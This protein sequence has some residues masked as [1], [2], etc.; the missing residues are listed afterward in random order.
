MAPPPASPTPTTE[1][2]DPCRVEVTDVALDCVTLLI[3]LGGL[4]GNGAVLWLLGW[5]PRRD[6]TTF[7]AVTSLCLW[8]EHGH[9]QMALIAMYVLNFLVF[10]PPMVISSTILFIKVQCGSQQCPPKRL[11]TVI[12]LTVLFFLLFALPL[13]I[14]NFLQQFAYT[15]VPSQLVFLL[16][17][18][19]SSINPI[20]YVLVG[21]CRR[22]CSLV[23]PRVAFQRVFEEPEDSAC[24]N[25]TT[26]GTLAPAC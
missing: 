23:P 13:S 17:C 5:R 12:F 3:C 25:T 15:H 1:G 26:M 10:A 8:H 7:A 21:T 6:P 4:L 9:C 19:N 11:H 2:G 20:T 14:S 22:R 16:A 18:I 24:S